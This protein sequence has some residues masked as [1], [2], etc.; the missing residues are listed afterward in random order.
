VH[1]AWL[2]RQA[3]FPRRERRRQFR[4]AGAGLGDEPAVANDV[5]AD[6]NP[7]APVVARARTRF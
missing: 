7:L 6:G 3:E 1:G 2:A 5:E 4:I